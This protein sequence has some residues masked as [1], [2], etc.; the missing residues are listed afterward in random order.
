MN[1]YIIG[2]II[3][4]LVLFLIYNYYSK[5]DDFIKKN[6]IIS[7][8]IQEIKEEMRNLENEPEETPPQ[9]STFS[10][11]INDIFYLPIDFMYKLLIT[12]G[13]PFFYKFYYKNI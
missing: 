8:N 13:R 5:I 10:D 7:Q 12:Y 11:N 1:S 3:I 9:N 6:I 2:I 4:L